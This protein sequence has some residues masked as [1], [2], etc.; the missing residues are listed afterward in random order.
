MV[1]LNILLLFPVIALAI[2]WSP[3]DEQDGYGY[4]RE[5]QNDETLPVVG[6]N[7]DVGVF[8]LFLLQV[9]SFFSSQLI[10]LETCSSRRCT[11]N[12]ISFDHVVGC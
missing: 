2:P 8:D 12:R 11:R 9:C 7:I 5:S 1:H 10:R 3:Y 6:S 4:P